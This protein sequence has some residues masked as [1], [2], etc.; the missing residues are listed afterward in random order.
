MAQAIAR[1]ETVLMVAAPG[2]GDDARR[3]CGPNVEVIELPIDDSWLRD[4]GPIFVLG[5]DGARIGVD[6]RFNAWG[7]RSSPMPMMTGS[8]S[9]SSPTSASRAIRL[10]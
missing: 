3:R 4:S 10:R 7:E 5:P 9:A 6:F 1:F 2:M 8:R